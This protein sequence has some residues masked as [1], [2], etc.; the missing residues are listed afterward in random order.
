MNTTKII[1]ALK[2]GLNR[3]YVQLYPWGTA[4]T[5]AFITLAKT[6]G[7]E[8]YDS[9]TISEGDLLN[10]ESFSKGYTLREVNNVRMI[11]DTISYWADGLI[12]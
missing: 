10:V 7:F 11:R 4:P 5:S 9:I 3:I 2:T 12:T 1:K 6:N 8:L